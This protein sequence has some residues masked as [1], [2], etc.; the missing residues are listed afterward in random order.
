[1][2]GHDLVRRVD[3]QGEVLIRCRKCSGYARQNG[4]KIDELLQAGESGHKRALEKVETNSDPRRRPNSCKVGKNQKLK[5]KRKELP[6]RSEYQRLSNEIEMGGFMAQKGLWNLARETM[7][8]DRGAMPKEE[9]DVIREAMAM[10]DENFLSSWLREDVEGK[11]EGEKFNKE[12]KEE[13]SR[14]REREEEKGEDQSVVV[15]RRCINPFLG[16]AFEKFSQGEESESCGTSW[17][18]FWVTLVVCLIVCLMCRR[19]CQL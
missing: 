2:G 11:G 17:V 7:L 14:K 4:T 6:A 3:R 19:V 15:K 16:D 5:E 18:I 9:G 8:Q 13:V 10:H 1:M 12:T